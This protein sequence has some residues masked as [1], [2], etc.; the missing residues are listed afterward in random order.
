MW[1]RWQFVDTCGRSIDDTNPL[2]IDVVDRYLR[3]MGDKTIPDE[4]PPS[5]E[6]FY[7]P[8]IAGINVPQSRC[9]EFLVSFTDKEHFNLKHHNTPMSQF[10]SPPPSKCAELHAPL[11]RRKDNLFP[12]RLQS[13]QYKNNSIQI[14]LYRSTISECHGFFVAY[15][16]IFQ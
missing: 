16:F 2:H 15:I 11:W 3:G 1:M 12:T 7:P 4:F 6:S 9:W 5:L 8:W 13:H 14:H 10:V